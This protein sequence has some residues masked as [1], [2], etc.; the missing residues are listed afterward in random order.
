MIALVYSEL[1]KY[2]KKKSIR[3][4]LFSFIFLPILFSSL[5]R[6]ADNT[7]FS[8]EPVIFLLNLCIVII[9]SGFISLEFEKGTLK[10]LLIQPISRIRMIYSKYFA[11]I[12]M[13]IFFYILFIIG[14]IISTIIIKGFIIEYS[15]VFLFTILQSIILASISFF[16]SL[17]LKSTS[18]T[19][20]ISLI[21]VFLGE[22]INSLLEKV[23]SLGKFSLLSNYDL[24]P[25]FS[26]TLEAGNISLYAAIGIL[27][28][29][30]LFFNILLISS[31]TKFEL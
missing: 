29:H 24:T 16:L 28:I 18:K 30:F 3:I 27:V 15:W 22:K 5:I 8:L 4:L 14:V 13:I 10:N 6:K 19:V 9:A 31:V 1:F 23:T 17:L 25:Y 21:I 12:I 26:S 11:L 7:L 20:L 2:L